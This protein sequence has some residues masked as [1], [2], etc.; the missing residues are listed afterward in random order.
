[1]H[2]N[3]IASEMLTKGVGF[4]RR[5]PRDWK[6]TVGRSSLARFVYHMV[7]PYQSVYTVSLGATA[8]QLG[9]V[10]SA[11]MGVAGLVSPFAGWFI[12]RIGVKKIY[13]I[14]IVF[15]PAEC[16]SHGLV[17]PY[18]ATMV[19]SLILLYRFSGN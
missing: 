13:L 9:I 5:Q 17:V 2:I 11:G 16:L 8:T 4:I 10:N 1:M 18:Q 14:G 15:L 19:N 12:D 7:L 3:E 6:I